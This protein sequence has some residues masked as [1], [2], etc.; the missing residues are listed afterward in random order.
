MIQELLEV[1]VERGESI[2]KIFA[3]ILIPG[4]LKKLG[5]LDVSGPKS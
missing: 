4:I 1:K 2:Y 3:K 5:A